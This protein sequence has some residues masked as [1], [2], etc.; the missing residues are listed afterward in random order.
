MSK[1]AY[2]IPLVAFAQTEGINWDTAQSH[3][4]AR[5]H[6]DI[7]KDADAEHVSIPSSEQ[8]PMHIKTTVTR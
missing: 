3:F 6:N 5:I 4:G 1:C 8:D 7:V 2:S